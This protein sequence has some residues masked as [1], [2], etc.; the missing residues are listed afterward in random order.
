VNEAGSISADVVGLRCVECNGSTEDRWA[1][2]CPNCGANARREVRYAEDAEDRLRVAL[3]TRPFDMWRY[4]ELLPVLRPAGRWSALAVGGT[5]L[6]DAPGLARQFDVRR[7]VV[8]DEARNLSGSL[9]DRATAVGVMLALAARRPAIACAST[10]N[11]AA[12]TAT[13]A[14]A[15][16]VPAVVLIPTRT[17]AGKLSQ[18]RAC[19]AVICQVDASYDKVWELCSA[20]AD[21]AGWLNRNCAVNPYLVEGKKTAGLELAEQLGDEITDW[22]AVG[23]GDGCTLAGIARGLIEAH[24][25]GLIPRRPRLLGVQPTGVQPL[26]RAFHDGVAPYTS[27]PDT[28]ADGL[29][30]GRP[31]NA[32]KALQAM[33]ALGGDL[34][35]VTDDALL[36]ATGWVARRSGVF[37]EPA[38]AAAFA[39]VSAARA[40]GSIAAGESVCIINTGTGL[41]DPSAI[42]RVVSTAEPLNLSTDVEDALHRITRIVATSAT[43]GCHRP[44]PSD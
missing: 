32:T 31:R 21:R 36:E 14:A 37:P 23:V 7:V 34:V 4:A 43:P 25:V 19:G 10:G 26:V 11:A 8:K 41:K 28:V 18:L 3:P 35:A 6:V 2:G 13:L 24:R 29:N 16:G 33:E 5:P 40:S 15:A 22:V 42:D 38:A 9:K 1:W 30:V 17:A 12:S 20:L 39:G 44:R 27:T